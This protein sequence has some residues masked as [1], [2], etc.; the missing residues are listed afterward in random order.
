MELNQFD[1][2]RANKST[3][4][5]GLE[6]RVPF[7][8]ANFL[9]VA[10][11]RF[12]M[13]GNSMLFRMQQC[14]I[15]VSCPLHHPISLPSHIELV[16]SSLP[17]LIMNATSSPNMTL[18]FP[19][20]CC[21]TVLQAINPKE[22]MITKVSIFIPLITIQQQHMMLKAQMHIYETLAAHHIHPLISC[23]LIGCLF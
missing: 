6:A 10:M 13:H 8:D 19:C 12:R 17:F 15:F 14:I 11:V 4:A 23:P 16:R 2:L 1:C 21:A 5:W 7:L 3:Q 20:I 9:N 18:S 22:K